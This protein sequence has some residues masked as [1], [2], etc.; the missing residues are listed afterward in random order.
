MRRSSSLLLVAALG[1]MPSP[2]ADMFVYFGSHAEGPGRGFSLAHFDTATGVLTKPEFLLEAAAPAFFVIHPDGR[3]LYASNS[4]MTFRGQPGAAVSAYAIDP[5]TARLTLLNQQ[6]SGGGDASYVSLDATGRYLFVANYQGG[7]FA[8]FA[9]QPD[10]SIGERTAFFQHTGSSVNPER[11]KHAYAHSIKVDPSNRF[12]LV[13]DLGLD[14]LFVYRFNAR[15]GSMQ[16]NDPPFVK[17]APGSGARHFTFHPN[18]RFVYLVNEMGSTVIAFAWDSAR[19]TLT[20][21][22]TIS[23]LPDGFKGVSNCAEIE[24]H[25]SGKFLYATNRGHDSLAVFAIDASSGRLTLVERVPTQ[26][27]TPRNFAFD[28]T[29]RWLLVTNHDSNNAVVFRIDENTGHLTQNGPPVPILYPFCERFLPV[30]EG[31]NRNPEDAL[32]RDILRQLIEIDTTAR[33]GNTGKAADALA[34]RLL[35]A[36]FPAADVQVVGPRPERA[37]LVARLRGTGARPPILLIAHLD[38]VEANRADWSTDPF[39]FVEKDGYFYG[40]GTIDIKDGD[41]VLVA[42]FIRMRKEG[43]RPD[44]DLI[45]ALTANEETGGDENGVAWLLAN[46]RPLIEAQYC[47]NL[48]GGGLE[49][50]GGR[51]LINEVQYSE[52]GYL[53]FVL[54]ARDKGG[55]S[56]VPGKRNAIYELSQALVRL[57]ALEFPVMLDAGRRAYF[58][59]IGARVGGQVAQAVS[60]MLSTDPPDPASVA[61]LSASPDWNAMLRSTCVA[62]MLA[63]GHA[64]N[65]LPQSARATVNCRILPGQ[66]PADVQQTLR[67]AI[68]DDAIS[69]TPLSPLDAVGS[70]ASPLDPEVMR[71]MRATTEALWP[72]V[73]AVPFMLQGATDGKYLRRAGIPTYGLSGIADDNDDIRAHGKDERISATA[74]YEGREFM[75]RLT[76]ALSSN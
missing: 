38:V 24:V 54:E 29:A 19:G 50:K 65:A 42:N 26:G 76:K 13:A 62:T 48:D 2:A 59:A 52:K 16:P 3:H 67:R 28:P 70:P 4:I 47:L 43:Y 53:T 55:H 46:R 1:A 22:Q 60:K 8:A 35:A 69:L 17:V 36:G 63:A 6:P 25:P 39:Q 40:R 75:Y 18:G 27:K 30:P 45:V 33:T 56:S 61:R 23:T 58:E 34:T 12:V 51:K 10:G 64:E 32:V 44:R 74:L 72:G 66:A 41:A 7:N 5:A 49:M 11:Q 37:N 15:D 68:A 57:S 21:I 31:R 73:P 9:L 14:E 20:E 71:A